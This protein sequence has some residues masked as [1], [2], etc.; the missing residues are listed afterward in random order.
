[1]TEVFL[2]KHIFD[3]FSLISGFRFL[4]L[5]FTFPT[6][7]FM[8]TFMSSFCSHFESQRKYLLK[9]HFHFIQAAVQI[10]FAAF[11]LSSLV[12]RTSRI[13]WMRH[14]ITRTCCCRQWVY[15]LQW[16][17][18][19]LVSVPVCLHSCISYSWQAWRASRHTCSMRRV[20]VKTCSGRTITP[21]STVSRLGTYSPF[22]W[23][24]PAQLTALVAFWPRGTC[25]YI[26]A[27][28]ILTSTQKWKPATISQ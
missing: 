22:F 11:A 8:L 28:D 10:Y 26:G 14:V 5:C 15:A 21:T 4:F 13:V 1:M 7:H 16:W 3:Y 12:S 19:W 23:L 20:F 6:D 25:S 24:G 2:L 17:Q 18:Q 27:V 9:S